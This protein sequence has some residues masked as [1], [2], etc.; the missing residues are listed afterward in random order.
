VT[1]PKVVPLRRTKQLPCGVCGRPVEVGLTATGRLLRG[2]LLDS[3]Q[4][5]IEPAR[6]VCRDRRVIFNAFWYQ[7]RPDKPDKEEIAV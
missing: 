4:F 3:F 7:C 5:S 6:I 1:K 2:W